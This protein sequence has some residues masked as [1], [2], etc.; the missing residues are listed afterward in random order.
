[1]PKNT[2]KAKAADNPGPVEKRAQ[3]LMDKYHG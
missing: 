2:G 1:M 3:E